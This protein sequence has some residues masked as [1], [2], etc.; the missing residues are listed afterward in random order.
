LPNELLGEIFIHCLRQRKPLGKFGSPEKLNPND[1]PLV[2]CAVC[3]RWRN[4]VFTTPGMWGSLS[5]QQNSVLSDSGADYAEFCRTWLSR[6]GTTPLL[7]EFE[8]Y[9]EDERVL[10]LLEIIGGLAQQ[11]RGVWLTLDSE[12][13]KALRLPKAGKFPFLEHLALSSSFSE[14]SLSFCDA[15]NLQD[16]CLG[17]STPQIRLPWHQ[18]TSYETWTILVPRFLQILRD[19]PNLVRTRFGI[20]G[21]VSPASL[22]SIVIPL[23]HMHVLKLGN[24]DEDFLPMSILNCLKVPALKHLTLSFH[25]AQAFSSDA[26]PFLSFVSRSSFRLHTLALSLM[27]VTTEDLIECL[28][29]TP[30][31]VDLKLR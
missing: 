27:P 25:D 28:K 20:E 24:S 12:L 22:P 17:E 23:L 26:T 9:V 4:I 11:W 18:L 14:L 19:A 15:P 6:A 13:T 7:I 16:V 21:P 10:S 31:V 29:A 3:R 2:L 1:A 5:I 30:T 8:A